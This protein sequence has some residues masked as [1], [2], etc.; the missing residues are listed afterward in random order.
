MKLNAYCLDWHIASSNA[1]IDML[2]EP[3]NSYAD[4]NL[5][6]WNGE[7]VPPEALEQKIVIFC[8]LP[9]SDKFLKTYRGKVV[10]LP[11]WDQAQGYEQEWWNNLPKNVYVVGFSKPVR[12][13]A[14]NAG[15]QLVSLQYFKNPRGLPPAKWSDGGIIFYWNRTGMIGPT[16]LEKFCTAVGARE[17]YFLGQIDPRIESNKYYELYGK[18]G[19]TRVI[20]IKPASQNSFLNTTSKANIVIAPRTSEGV[21][22][23]FLEA[24]AR[25]CGVL[26][27][28]APTMNEYIKHE[29]NGLLLHNKRY[30]I[31]DNLFGRSNSD[32]HSGTPYYLSDDQPWNKIASVNFERLGQNARAEHV[33]GFN[34]WQ[35]SIPKYAEFVLKV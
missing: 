25:G 28:D 17:I 2:V 35:E 33:L 1:F 29:R 32:S 24:M 23:T 10:W 9:P 11:M 34:Q 13:K 3:L 12:Q 20:N 26:A 14:K 18:L 31:F 22:M 6:A 21:G 7:D 30:G 8:M 5:V 4:I 19:N 16:F 27:Y 15:L